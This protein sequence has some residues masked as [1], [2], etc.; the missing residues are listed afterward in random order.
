ML[1]KAIRVVDKNIDRLVIIVFLLFFL[2][3][4]YAMYDALMVYNH[5][6]DE[7][8]L[9]YNLLAVMTHIS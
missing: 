7:S 8:A 9:K 5:A 6:N 4:F 1:R 2:I 3:C